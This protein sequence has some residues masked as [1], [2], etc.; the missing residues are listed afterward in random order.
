MIRIL[1]ILILVILFLILTMPFQLVMWLIGKK[2]PEVRDKYTLAW[3]SW[4]FNMIKVISGVKLTV[5][6]EENIPVDRGALFIGNHRSIFDIVLTYPLMKGPTG[7]VSKKE[8]EKVPLLNVWMWS[9]HCLFLNRKDTRAG[10][11]M[12]LKAIDSVKKGISIFIF[13]EGTRNRDWEDNGLLPFRDGAFKIATKSGAPIVPV[14]IVGTGDVL[15][16]HIPFIRPAK[17]IVE[18]GTPIET[19]DLDRAEQKN[20][21]TNVAQ[22]ITDTYVKNKETLEQK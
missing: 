6:G 5:I 21:S 10:L 3:V 9:L 8:V 15:E 14:S 17:V 1:I 11:D 2:K 20:L 18:F 19:K 13:P 16:K 4:A 22:I 12:V 7:Y